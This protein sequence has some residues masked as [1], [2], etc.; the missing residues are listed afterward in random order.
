VTGADIVDPDAHAEA[1]QRRDDAPR[2]IEVVERLA[3]GDL[4]QDLAQRDR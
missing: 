1:L 2:N 3:L 4:E